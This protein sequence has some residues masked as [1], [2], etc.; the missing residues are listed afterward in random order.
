MAFAE[1]FTARQITKAT[2]QAMTPKAMTEN[3]L[4]IPITLP[5]RQFHARILF[6]LPA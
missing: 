3:A 2:T 1:A 5:S 6:I 4:F